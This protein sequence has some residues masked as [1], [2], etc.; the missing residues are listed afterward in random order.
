MFPVQTSTTHWNMVLSFHGSKLCVKEAA[1]QQ[2]IATWM[3]RIMFNVIHSTH[4][5][6]L[7]IVA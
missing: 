1:D 4:G 5:V 2:T 3:R 7:Y 6:Y